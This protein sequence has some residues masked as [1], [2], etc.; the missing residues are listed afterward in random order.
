MHRSHLLIPNLDTAGQAQ[1]LGN[2]L[3]ALSGISQIEV[4]ASPGTLMVEYDQLYLSE[5]SLKEFVKGAGYPSA[6]DE[7]SA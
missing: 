7:H 5:E 1:D 4:K 2:A 6:G 3:M